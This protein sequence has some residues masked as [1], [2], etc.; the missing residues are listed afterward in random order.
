ME[1]I[2]WDGAN[3]AELRADIEALL[4]SSGE[5]K[6]L[7]DFLKGSPL[8]QSWEGDLKAFCEEQLAQG[9][10]EELTPDILYDRLVI[11]G[12]ADIPETAVAEID[13]ML[14]TF[15]SAQLDDR[16]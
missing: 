13:R 12:K 15:L 5:S 3:E 16:Y 6:K 9:D 11:S 10:S 2:R 7:I 14:A 8:L 4:V 1:K